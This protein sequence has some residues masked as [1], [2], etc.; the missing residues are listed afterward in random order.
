MT[1]VNKIKSNITFSTVYRVYRCNKRAGGHLLCIKT[2]INRK[3]L[4]LKLKIVM[5]VSRRKQ[6]LFIILCIVKIQ[7]YMHVLYNM[8][9]A[10]EFYTTVRCYFTPS[11]YYY[12]TTFMS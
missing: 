1:I 8:Y 5:G 9:C 7:Y 2:E 3:R 11:I 6:L 10:A 4:N 12:D